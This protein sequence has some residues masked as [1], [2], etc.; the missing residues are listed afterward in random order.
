[1]RKGL[2]MAAINSQQVAENSQVRILKRKQVEERTGLPRSSI[3]AAMAAGEFP[4][5][6]KLSAKS[7]GWVECEVVAWINARI[8]ASRG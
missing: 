3:Y 5:Q 7:V 1:M 6:I 2:I 8:A 4:G